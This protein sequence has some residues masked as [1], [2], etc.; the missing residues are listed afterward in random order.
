MSD[1]VT[2]L[3]I[4]SHVAELP[5]RTRLTPGESTY[6]VPRAE[7][8]ASENWQIVDPPKPKTPR[9]GDA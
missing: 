9:K 4:G 6:R 3:W 2:A 1:L 8:E 7:A 5:D